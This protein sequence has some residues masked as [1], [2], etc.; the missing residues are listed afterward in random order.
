VE[1][2]TCSRVDDLTSYEFVISFGEFLKTYVTSPESTYL[3]FEEKLWRFQKELKNGTTQWMSIV[4]SALD[5][6]H[7]HARDVEEDEESWLEE[8]NR[9]HN[10][11]CD[12]EEDDEDDEEC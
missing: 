9:K 10:E 6:Y 12:E 1:N 4:P 3:Y 2:F 5:Q 8:E 7:W 11:N